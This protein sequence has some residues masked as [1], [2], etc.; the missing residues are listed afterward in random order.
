MEAT[1][2]SVYESNQKDWVK[3]LMQ[4]LAVEKR[5]FDVLDLMHK[6]KEFMKLRSEVTNLEMQ[7]EDLQEQIE[8]L[9]IQQED[10]Q[11]QKQEINALIKWLIA[12]NRQD[13]LIRSTQ[14]PEYQQQLINEMKEK[15]T[16]A[17]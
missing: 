17:E 13:E 8:D 5:R 16:V 14:D 1:A 15:N 4:E 2:Q 12:G 6:D 7:N 10:L 3:E 9:Q 11:A